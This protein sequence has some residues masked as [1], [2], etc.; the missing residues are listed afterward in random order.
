MELSE[1]MRRV[2]LG[3]REALQTLIARHGG[4]I[5]QRAL[6]KTGDKALA[7]EVTQKIFS[8][9]VTTLQSNA[10]DSGWQLWLDAL[11]AR[12]IEACGH[13][14][15][16]AFSA[17][18]E[19]ER[20]PYAETPPA[21][22]AQTQPRPVA[23]VT[24]QPYAPRPAEAPAARQPYAPRPDGQAGYARPAPRYVGAQPRPPRPDRQPRSAAAPSHEA[25]V[26]L[27]EPR[28]RNGFG[29]GLG[30]LVLCLLCLGLIW[31]AVGICMNMSFIPKYDL[32]YTWFD[33]H[34][35]QFF[36]TN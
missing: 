17:K 13:L 10:D 3:D 8:E 9:L 32:G 20:A 18:N 26:S 7:K 12:N 15:S 22:T 21:K 31:V 6:A 36:G 1:L 5:Y 28:R 27:Y 33:R 2:C 16:G 19:T 30:V 11:A 29:Y 34:M 23:P 35:F 25:A 24:R 4:Q 14:K